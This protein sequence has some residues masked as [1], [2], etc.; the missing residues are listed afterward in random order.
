LEK[1]SEKYKKPADLKRR[2]VEFN[3]GDLV[4]AV[5]TKDRFPVGT[6]NKLKARKFGPVEVVKRINENA[7]KLKLPEDIYTSDVF[8]VKHLIPYYGDEQSEV[9]EF[10]NSRSNFSQPGEDDAG[11][12]VGSIASS[13]EVHNDL[14]PN[15]LDDG[16]R[17]ILQSYGGRRPSKGRE[18]PSEGRDVQFVLYLGRLRPSVLIGRPTDL[19]DQR[20]QPIELH[21][22]VQQVLGR[23]RPSGISRFNEERV[24]LLSRLGIGRYKEGGSESYIVIGRATTYDLVRSYEECWGRRVTVSLGRERPNFYKSR[25]T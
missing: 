17:Q 4:Y 15:V 19:T 12:E 8:N 1:S 16:I 25:T 3:E 22:S 7:Y 21:D 13:R 11:Q 24:N 6:Y 9:E 2:N 14:Q 20:D 10:T 5:L 23:Q 18:R